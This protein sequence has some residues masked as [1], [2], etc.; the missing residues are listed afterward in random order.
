MEGD[1][2]NAQGLAYIPHVRLA[3]H[4]LA[5]TPTD[6]DQCLYLHGRRLWQLQLPVLPPRHPTQQLRVFAVLVILPDHSAG[7]LWHLR[8]HGNLLAL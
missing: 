8:L 7:S 3:M 1:Q 4:C 6:P 5:F 2:V